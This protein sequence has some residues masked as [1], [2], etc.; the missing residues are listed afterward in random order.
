MK[1]IRETSLF[2]SV[3]IFVVLSIY[4]T[5]RQ[6]EQTIFE[7]IEETFDVTILSDLEYR[8]KEINLPFSYHYGGFSADSFQFVEHRKDEQI[9]HKKEAVHHMLSDT[10]KAAIVKQ[11]YLLAKNPVRVS[12]LDSIFR[13]ELGKRG[14]ITQTAVTFF[15]RMIEETLLY[16]N[17]ERETEIIKDM[18]VYVT[19]KRTTGIYGEITLLGFARVTPA[20]VFR[21]SRWLFISLLT[22]ELIVSG[23]LAYFVMRRRKRIARQVSVS[24]PVPASDPPPSESFQLNAIEHVLICQDGKIQLTEEMFRLFEYIWNKDPHFAS[25]SDISDFMYK[26]VSIKTGKERMMQT[27]KQLRIRL[28]SQNVVKI[29]NVSGK[30]YRIV[31]K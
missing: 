12:V 28:K 29:E 20:M 16:E 3:A 6:A 18:A 4:Y 27:V 24:E 13:V 19:V 8:S 22:G 14:V 30:G 25:Y 23:L 10:E 5:Y 31:L 15:N 17:R 26:N 11:T 9:I 7:K 21:E 1:Y 2:F